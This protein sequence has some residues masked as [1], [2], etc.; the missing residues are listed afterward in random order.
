MSNFVK[1]YFDDLIAFIKDDDFTRQH[2]LTAIGLC[3]RQK[4][5]THASFVP[6]HDCD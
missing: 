6:N 3:K 1:N 2:V 5:F 4:I